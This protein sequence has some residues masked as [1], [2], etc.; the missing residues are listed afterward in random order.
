MP[1]KYN[2]VKDTLLVIFLSLGGWALNSFEMSQNIYNDALFKLIMVIILF[3]PLLLIILK[4]S[5]KQF[6]RKIVFR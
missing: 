1:V 3:I 6:I 5:E 2:L 4:P